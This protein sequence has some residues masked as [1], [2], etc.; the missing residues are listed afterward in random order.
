MIKKIYFGVGLG[1]IFIYVV[2]SLIGFE[3][4]PPKEVQ[5][6]GIMRMTRSKPAPVSSSGGTYP[7]GYPGGSSPRGGK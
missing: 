6:L 3:A 1:V 5:S 7:G 2:S 4:T